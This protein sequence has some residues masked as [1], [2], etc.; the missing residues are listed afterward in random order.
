MFTKKPSKQAQDLEALRSSALWYLSRRDHS[1]AEL[2]KKLSAK[3]KQKDWIDKIIKE[4]RAYS[5][6]DDQRFAEHFLHQCQAKAYGML[7][8]Q[9]DFQNKGLALE[10]LEN[11]EEYR[12]FDYVSSAVSLL[13]K[14]YK[15]SLNNQY[16]QQQAM[17]FLQTKGHDFDD[18]IKAIDIHNSNMPECDESPVD[19]AL[20]LLNK[21]F[22]TSI[23][24]IKQKNKALRFLASRAYQ[25]EDSM[26][27]IQLFNEQ[28]KNV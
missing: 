23:S 24:D 1:E 12:Q 10:L 28:Y 9:K 26:Q 17:Q 21:K 2:R 4:F 19:E 13:S 7:R 16:K 8:I 27:A 11:L 18:I 22:S 20:S 15:N 25:Y 6:I 3:T 14:K 5:Y